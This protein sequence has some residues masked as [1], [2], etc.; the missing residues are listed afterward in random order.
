MPDANI[1]DTLSEMARVLTSRGL[2]GIW[3]ITLVDTDGMVLASWQSP[4]NKVSPE[5]L[6][7]FIQIFHRT[8]NA[9]KQS[10]VG[11]TRFDDII[12]STTLMYQLIKPLADATCFVV[13]SAPRNMPLGEIRTQCNIYAPRLEQALP[14]HAPSPRSDGLG[15]IVP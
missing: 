1:K 14:G 5:G 9:F 6:G 10:P 11:F 7:G 8:M 3:M 2:G 15:T 12:F 4:D 13:V